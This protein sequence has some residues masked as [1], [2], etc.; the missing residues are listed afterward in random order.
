[1]SL[2]KCSLF[3]LQTAIYRTE[4]DIGKVLIGRKTMA[5][6]GILASGNH[7]KTIGRNL[8]IPLVPG[9]FG[10]F[11]FFAIHTLP[12][13]TVPHEGNALVFVTHGVFGGEC[14]CQ[15]P[16]GVEKIN[17]DAFDEFLSRIVGDQVAQHHRPT[18]AHP[19]QGGIAVQH[20]Y[21][22]N[23][24][25]GDIF[26]GKNFHCLVIAIAI[27]QEQAEDTEEK[28]ECAHEI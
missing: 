10:G 3:D 11:Q 20:V 8:L 24:L 21:V 18:N 5:P 26:F 13:H 22:L 25:N 19:N 17:F 1:M 16:I 7:H 27:V 28:S 23:P 9:E 2:C 4:A 15:G 14:T 12:D 6:N